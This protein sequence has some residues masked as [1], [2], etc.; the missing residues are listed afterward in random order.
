MCSL[1]RVL[2]KEPRVILRSADTDGVSPSM[3]SARLGV[4]V[5]TIHQFC[6]Q[7]ALYSALRIRFLH[8]TPRK[9][10]LVEPFQM[11]GETSRNPPEWP[12]A[13]RPGL[14][15]LATISCGNP[16]L[17]FDLGA[18]RALS[19]FAEG[20]LSLSKPAQP[21]PPCRYPTPATPAPHLPTAHGRRPFYVFPSGQELLQAETGP[22]GTL[23]KT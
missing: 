23:S 2:A 16:A 18:C 20:R 6:W 22:W 5:I 7:P 21:L 14:V 12:S 4:G 19:P 3:F 1:A 17:C 15:F 8:T 10:S 11:A 9:A 13:S